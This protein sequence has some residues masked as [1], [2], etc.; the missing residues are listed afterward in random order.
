M[1]YILLLNVTKQHD[2]I[3]CL[4]RRHYEKPHFYFKIVKFNYE[5]MILEQ[6]KNIIIKV[7]ETDTHTTKL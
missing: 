6:K 5:D 4:L 2:S 7:W 1:L 3:L